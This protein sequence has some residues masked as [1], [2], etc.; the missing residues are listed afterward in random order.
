MEAVSQV[1][2]SHG[3]SLPQEKDRRVCVCCRFIHFQTLVVKASDTAL[4]QRHTPPYCCCALRG[5]T[6]PSWRER[7]SP[8]RRP[9]AEEAARGA[10]QHTNRKSHL[11]HFKARILK[12][13]H[14]H[15]EFS[16]E[17]TSRDLTTSQSFSAPLARWVPSAHLDFHRRSQSKEPIPQGFTAVPLQDS[18]PR[19]SG[20]EPWR[21]DRQ[22]PPGA[23]R[24]CA[25]RDRRRP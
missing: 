7:C 21:S 10:S 17:L 12:G 3:C 6:L 24:S 20:P 15:S 19:P 13:F 16:R 8:P 5:P 9:A 22:G 23:R 14:S 4:F 11:A 1:T 25:E 2:W 18:N